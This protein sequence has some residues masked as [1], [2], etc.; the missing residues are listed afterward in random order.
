VIQKTHWLILAA[1]LLAST[2]LLAEPAQD[3]TLKDINGKN[4]TLTEYLEQGPVL[5][6]FWATWCVPCKKEMPGLIEIW[7]EYAEEGLC[8]L[9]IAVDTPR[10]QSKVKSYARSQKWE[11]PVLLDTSGNLMRKY[12]GNNPPLT[13]IID[14][15]GEIV[16]KHSGYAPGDEEKIEATVAML[17]EPL[18]LEEAPAEEQ[19][20]E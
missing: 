20:P 1:L 16:Y 6:A 17:F 13:V 19:E 5:I 7:Q 18:Q 12:Q 15:T 3:F 9:A 10:T 8:L 11:M 4:R 2:T 14:Q